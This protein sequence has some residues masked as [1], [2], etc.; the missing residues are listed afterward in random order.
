MRTALCIAVGL[1]WAGHL[2]AQQPTL[3]IPVEGYTYDA[4]TRSLRAVMGFPG[5]ASYGP[6]LRDGLDFAS[7]APRQNYGIGFKS[8]ECFYL[9]GVGSSRIATATLSGVAKQPDGIVWS[10]DGSLAVLYSRTGNWLQV[11]SGFPQAPVAAPLVD[12]TALGGSLTAVAAQSTRIAVA[13]SGTGA[14]VYQSTDNQ[15]F[16]VVASLAKPIAL[17]YSSDGATLYALD[18]S[19]P[20]IVGLSVSGAVSQTIP[21]VGLTNPIAIQALNDSQ[22]QAVLYVAAG[23]DRK[24]RIVDIATGQTVNDVALGFQPTS[25]DAFGSESF[26]AA[27]RSQASS[28]LW[29]F[30][31]APQPAAYFVPAVQR[32]PANHR[33]AITGR[34]R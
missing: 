4:P 6:I 9:A 12:A 28:P 20:Q 2:A 23:T 19:V 15:T 1:T 27:V 3:A 34:S 17:S 31:S 32:P 18:A 26:I 22:Y 11:V 21:L 33:V 29:L 25:L 24:L 7:I 30:S 14:G 5:A 13:I 10:A 16:S 8:G